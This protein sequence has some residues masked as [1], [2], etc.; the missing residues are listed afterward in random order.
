M[1]IHSKI[2]DCECCFLVYKTE[3][4]YSKRDIGGIKTA[5]KL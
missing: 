3:Q 1:E 2:L 4:P 5:G